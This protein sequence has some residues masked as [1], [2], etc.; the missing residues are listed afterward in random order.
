MLMSN[1]RKTKINSTST[2]QYVQEI[3][4]KLPISSTNFLLTK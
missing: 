3:L 1:T 4:N 2:K